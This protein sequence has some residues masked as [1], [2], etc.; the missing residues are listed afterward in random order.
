MN[1]LLLLLALSGCDGEATKIEPSA[2][3]AAVEAILP[4]LQTGT[5]LFSRG[6][7]L[8][9]KV[10]TASPYT[11]VAGVVMKDGKPFVYDS[12]NGV[13]A[14][15]LPFAEWLEAQRPDTLHIDQPTEAFSAERAREF[16]HCLDEN[17]GRPYAIKHHLTGKRADGLHCAEYMTDALCRAQLIKANRPSR[18]SPASLREGLLSTELY[19]AGTTVSLKPPKT[20]AEQ[21]TGWCSKLWIDTKVCTKN[22]CVQMRRWFLCR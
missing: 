16:V 4:E 8:A 9:V 14:R 15:C 7:C 21:P 10:F 5:L 3:E 2:A 17:L 13:G 11:H 18:V 1:A 22:C 6:D 19:V 12:M 20:A